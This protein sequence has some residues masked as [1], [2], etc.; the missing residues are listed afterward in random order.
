VGKLA[1]F[2][3]RILKAKAKKLEA[4]FTEALSEKLKTVVGS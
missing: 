2:G 3:D 4:E 1:M